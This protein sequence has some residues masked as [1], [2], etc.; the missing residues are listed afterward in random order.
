MNEIEQKC[1][2]L[3]TKR[4]GMLFEFEKE[5]TK[6][7]I[8]KDQMMEQKKCDLEMLERLQKKTEELLKENER[9]KV[10]RNQKKVQI[11]QPVAYM[12]KIN[13][14]KENS[15]VASQIFNPTPG[16]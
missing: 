11:S 2:E 16:K 7:S 1:K 14:G 6:W 12:G 10:D 15:M 13:F 8:E 5:R 4:T 3:E 9:L